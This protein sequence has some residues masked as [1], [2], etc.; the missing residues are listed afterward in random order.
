MDLMLQFLINVIMIFIIY[1]TINIR[2]PHPPTYMREV[3]DYEK[4]NIEKYLKCAAKKNYILKMTKKLTDSY[5]SSKTYWTI[6]NRLL[7]NKKLSNLSLS[8]VSW[9]QTLINKQ[10]F[11]ITFLSL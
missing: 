4:A 7:Y 10:T 2:V 8:M 1:G 11:L 3:W 9:F 6:L 5:T